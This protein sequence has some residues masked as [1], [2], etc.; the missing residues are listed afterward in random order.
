MQKAVFLDRDGTI[1]IDR[2]YVYRKEDFEYIKGAINALQIFENAGFR[3]VIVTNQSGIARG[4]YTEND[5]LDL[6][7]WMIQDLEKKGIHISGVY[8]CPHHPCGKILQYQV[9]CGCR[10]PKTS[11]FWHAAHELHIDMNQSYAI[12]DKMR[13]LE[14]CNESGTKGILLQQDETFRGLKKGMENICVCRNLL[15]AAKMIVC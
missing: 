11:L 3:L 4:Y 2:H 14:I 1:N 12:G 7:K 9:E 6:N 8:F 5:Y 10:K 13:D 15:E